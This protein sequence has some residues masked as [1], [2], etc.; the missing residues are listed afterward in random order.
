MNG[1]SARLR[2]RR[3]RLLMTMS[4]SGPE[5][6]SHSPLVWA[7]SCKLRSEKSMLQMTNSRMTDD[8]CQKCMRRFYVVIR[9]S[10]FVILLIVSRVFDGTNFIAELGGLLVF[11]GGDC[12]FHFAS[13]TD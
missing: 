6:R 13:Q 3:M 10:S 5:P 4:D 12:F 1:K 7:I 11:L 9:A 8:E 2:A